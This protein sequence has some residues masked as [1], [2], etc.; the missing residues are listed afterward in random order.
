MN[1]DGKLVCNS[2]P[3]ANAKCSSVVPGI[4]QIMV[5][6]GASSDVSDAVFSIVAAAGGNGGNGSGGGDGAQA[7]SGQ[8]SAS[9]LENIK[10]TLD[11]I[12]KTINSWR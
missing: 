6:D 4:Y 12:Q 10:A 7:P 3:L 11:Q 9:I 5:L 8:Y 2:L 1:W